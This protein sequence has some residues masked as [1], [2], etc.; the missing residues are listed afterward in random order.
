MPDEIANPIAK[1]RFVEMK[2]AMLLYTPFFAS[3]ML[4]MMRLK[5]VKSDSSPPIPTAGTDGYTIYFNEDFLA[6]LKLEE[7]VFLCCH[8]IGHAMWLHM[9]RGRKYKDLGFDG[10]EFSPELWNIAGDFII[11]DMLKKCNIGS[12]PKGGLLDP[13]YSCDMQVEEVYRDLYRR[14]KNKLPKPGSGAAGADGEANNGGVG[15]M[16]PLDTHIYKPGNVSEAEMKRAVQSAASQAKAV[17]HL[18]AHLEKF[19]NEI[20]NPKVN[21]KERLR[22][23]VTR[24]AE[25]DATTW[26]TPHRRRLITQRV[27]FPSYT[28]VGCG[29]IVFATDTSGSMGQK[30]YDAATAELSDIL[31][32]CRPEGV[33]ALSCDAKVHTAELLPSHHDIVNEPLKMKGGGG[34][35]FRPVFEWVEN[36]GV[37]PVMLLFFTDLMGGFPDNPPPYPVIWIC[38]TDLVGPF[39]ET[40]K[41]ELN[42]YEAC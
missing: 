30:E 19:V 5:V 8:E 11:N 27:Y 9:D 15:D 36:E 4:D 23:L 1:Q 21:W 31:N 28:G 3:L 16:N 41:V 2:T 37:E 7:A 18:P 38:T 17:G 39:G 12:M 33:W 34:T 29:T 14:M 10:K 40:I 6:S 13:K 35:D 22:H 20:L 26:T 42:E 24:T 32:T 25:R